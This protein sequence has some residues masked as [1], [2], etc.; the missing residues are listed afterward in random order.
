MNSLINLCCA[1]IYKNHNCV[2][3][4]NQES[5]KEILDSL[6][7]PFLEDFLSNECVQNSVA[8]SWITCKNLDDGGIIS[9]SCLSVPSTPF[10]ET[11]KPSKPIPTRKPNFDRLQ[12][13]NSVFTSPVSDPIFTF[14]HLLCPNSYIRQYRN[15]KMA[16]KLPTRNSDEDSV[17]TSYQKH[18]LS[19]IFSGEQISSRNKKESISHANVAAPSKTFFEQ[20]VKIGE[21][22][23][24]E[25]G[26]LFL[27]EFLRMTQIKWLLL[28]KR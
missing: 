20:S 14:S 4:Q 12:K 19:K 23:N 27:V 17:P 11:E 6:F 5:N 3:K 8:S 1:N 9:H 10:N 28:F 18:K 21:H 16:Q 24:F 13:R 25:K 22:E 2:C 7:G 26:K 15:Q